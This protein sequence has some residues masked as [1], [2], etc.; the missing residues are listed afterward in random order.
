M[1]TI[2]NTPYVMTPNSCLHLENETVRVD[3]EHVKKLQVPLHHLC[4]VVC[5]GNIMISPE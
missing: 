2:Q 3:V 1:H 5:L 4:S